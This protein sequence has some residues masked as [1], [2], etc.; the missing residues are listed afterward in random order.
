MF[1]RKKKQQQAQAQAA[2]A[3]APQPVDYDNMMVESELIE[4]DGE[5]Y[6]LVR[7]G[8]RPASLEGLNIAVHPAAESSVTVSLEPEVVYVEENLDEGDEEVKAPRLAKMPHLVDYVLT[9]KLSR[10]MKIHPVPHQDHPVH[11]GGQGSR[12][13]GGGKS[14]GGSG[15]GSGRGCGGQRGRRSHRGV[16]SSRHETHPRRAVLPRGCVPCRDGVVIMTVTPALLCGF[17]IFVPGGIGG[18][19]DAA[20]SSTD[21]RVTRAS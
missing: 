1:G 16:R 19:S 3:A 14:R 10:S 17:F 2:A 5:D 4:D 6:V 7:P 13:G 21:G 20:R 15:C 12:E 18:S 11:H 9:M 8:V